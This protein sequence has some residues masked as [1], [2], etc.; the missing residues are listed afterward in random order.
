[1]VHNHVFSQRNME[2]KYQVGVGKYL[3][4]REVDNIGGLQIIRVGRNPLLTRY[5]YTDIC[6]Y[7][8]I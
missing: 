7:V 3:K 1:M 2:T 5:I 6:M 8:Y 4:K